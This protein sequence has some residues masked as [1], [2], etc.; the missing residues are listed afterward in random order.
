[1]KLSI[2]NTF[3]C[4]E[5]IIDI[6]IKLYKKGYVTEFCCSGHPEDL[7]PYV[8]F[9]RISSMDLIN[10]HPV[11]W[12]GDVDGNAQFDYYSIRR[13][14][15]IKEKTTNDPERLVDIAMI[16]LESWVDSLPDAVFKGIF[17]E[18]KLEKIEE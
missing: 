12:Y 3:K 7:N 11:N 15:S 10:T 18:Y 9:D 4:D 2:T 1:M 5:K 16:E 8:A 14:F 6:I 13:K 17:N